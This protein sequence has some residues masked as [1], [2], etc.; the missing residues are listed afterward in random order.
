[1]L[2]ILRV[3]LSSMSRTY[4]VWDDLGAEPV[5]PEPVDRHDV[6]LVASLL[7]TIPSQCERG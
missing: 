1:M 3:K 6:Q 7:Q 4:V 2:K 5:F